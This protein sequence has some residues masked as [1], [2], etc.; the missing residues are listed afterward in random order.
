MAGRARLTRPLAPPRNAGVL[1]FLPATDFFWRVFVAVGN[2]GCVRSAPS[3]TRPTA[4]GEVASFPAERVGDEGLVEAAARGDQ[5][6]VAVVWDR[7]S[8]LVRGILFGALGPDSAI[9]DLLQEVF[10]AFVRGARNI[11]DGSRLRAYL[12]GAAVRLAAAE[13]RRRTVRRWVRLSKT[14]DLPETPVSPRDAE[15][16][17]VLLALQRVLGRL[18]S[19]RRMAFVL[20]HIEGLEMMEAASALRVSESTL[21]RELARAREQVLLGASREP[22]LAEFLERIRSGQS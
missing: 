2:M 10:I 18:T 3:L 14:G 17:Q 8:E 9:D 12:A 19:R 16:R 1:R 4:Y 22:A 15:G 20:R 5:A 13:I 11:E 21:R 7:Y 6:A